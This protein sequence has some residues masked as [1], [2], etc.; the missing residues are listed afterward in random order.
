VVIPADVYA[1]VATRDPQPQLI[2][3][4]NAGH[5]FHGQLLV[6]RERVGEALKGI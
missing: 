5:F 6:L 2:R 3:I 4:E 1:W